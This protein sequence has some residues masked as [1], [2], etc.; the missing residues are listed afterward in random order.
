MAKLHSA[1]LFGFVV[2]GVIGISAARADA[3]GWAKIEQPD[4]ST[5]VYSNVHISVQDQQH[6]SMTSNDGK[7]TLIINKGACYAVGGLLKCLAASAELDQDNQTLPITLKSGT[8]WLNLSAKEH[9]LPHSTVQF[10]PR[11]VTAAVTTKSGTQ[12]ALS[13]TIDQV[14]K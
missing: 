10:P 9:T 1:L 11:G 4:G 14:T 7:G 8:V 2:A 5:K 12:V 13:G 6:L 3:T